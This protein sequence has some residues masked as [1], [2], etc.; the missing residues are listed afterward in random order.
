[1][2]RISLKWG[3]N[4]L[5]F[6]KNNKNHI[7]TSFLGKYQFYGKTSSEEDDSRAKAL[8]LKDFHGDYVNGEGGKKCTASLNIL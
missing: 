2:V 7:S 8:Q 6:H 5:K 1:M 4:P 3:E